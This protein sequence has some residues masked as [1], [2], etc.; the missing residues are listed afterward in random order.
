MKALARTSTLATLVVLFRLGSSAGSQRFYPDDPLWKE[1]PPRATLSPQ[2]RALSEILEGLSNLVGAPGERQPP[3]GVIE[4]VRTNTLGEVMDGPWY[5]NRHGRVRMTR[6]ALIRGP[7][8]SAPP[9]LDAPWKAL[10]VKPFGLRPGIL[11]RDAKND[12]YLLRFDPIGHP[13][14]STGAEIVASKFFYALGYH[15]PENHIVTFDRS[16]LVAA[17][18]GTGISS[19]GARRDLTEVDIDSFLEN[20]E[21]RRTGL[22]RAVATRVPGDWAGLL[23]PYQVYGERSDD[24]NDI[25]PHEH[26]RDLRGLFVFCAWLNHN[27]MRA[28]NTLD[29]VVQENGT[30]FIRHYLV[31]FTATLGSAGLQGEKKAWEG[32]ETLLPGKKIFENMLS[33]GVYTPAWM[34]ASYP[35]GD[36][37]GR[38]GYDT[39]DP[40][41]WTTNH[42]IAPFANRLPDDEFWAAKQVMA[43]SDDDIRTL[44]ST[45][46]YT[47]PEAADWIAN[48]L[49]E[50]RN[51]I[52]ETYFAKVLP[53]DDFRIDEG[54][55]RFRDLE[56]EY[57]FTPSREYQV[58]WLSVNNETELLAR[59]E[60]ATSFALPRE[61]K[62][63]DVGSY[64]AARIAG[65]EAGKEVT[66]YLRR[67]ADDFP[68]VG[69]ERS[70]PGKV[71]ADPRRDVEMGRSRY[72][73]L[74]DDQKA[75]FE[76]YAGAYSEKRGRDVTPQEYFDSLT[77][78][79]R[80]TFDA[81]TH[82]LIHS[83]LTDSEGRPL[84]RAIELVARLERIAGQYYGRSGDQQFRL[85]VDLVP[86]ARETLEKCREFRPDH[87]NTV[88]HVGYPH[89]FRQVGKEPTLQFSLSED[90]A[91]A[92]ID[93]DYR[94]SKSPQALFNG[95]LTSSNS[96]VRAG[97]NVVRHDRRWTG[98]VAWWQELF[99]KLKE[100]GDSGP[101]LLA[102]E[103]PEVPTPLPPNRPPGTPIEDIRDAVQEFLT[104]W[105]VRHQ[106]EEALDLLSPRCYACLNLDDDAF[107]ET[108]DSAR[109]REE[110]LTVMRYSA[111]QLGERR[112]LT[113]AID[114]VLPRDPTRIIVKQP[115]DS[116]FAL[117]SMSEEE[118]TQYLC[119]QK[120]DEPTGAPFYGV[121]FRFKRQGSAILGLLWTREEG[122]WRLVAYR[123]F[124]Q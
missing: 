31:D 32:N 18:D 41:D 108:L 14:L 51:R 12:L 26:R 109:A 29:A 72:A 81:I 44:V 121:L 80:T 84:G 91:Q 8:D 115:F 107:A 9:S 36:A 61:V 17:P 110:L 93:V 94:S 27:F 23:G 11:I 10:V 38:F 40:E 104:D 112:N 39:F 24:P 19:A 34:R 49:I 64:Y 47:S 76:K 106:Y 37:V 30:P 70:W 99:G 68:V 101:D 73:D 6:E 102:G 103:K 53:L 78:S 2:P 22:Y 45:G 117:F 96:D 119:G 46:Q 123:A 120:P 48:A 35:G 105:L 114:A 63:G 4:A 65:P 15:V 97:D 85:Y 58:R 21:G 52:G 92:D 122:N 56:V 86:G 90:G 82:A 66:V 88:Y 3:R 5:V 74:S 83:E 79:E 113:E 69:I 111:E 59:I 43:F 13:E 7:G 100:R 87:E 42:E 98:F 62:D 57:G 95:H 118:A 124:E 28:V 71:L 1:P 60:G 25:V 33:F 16:R 77:I 89:S 67:E 50:R 116:D 20:V 54:E 75:L 55:L